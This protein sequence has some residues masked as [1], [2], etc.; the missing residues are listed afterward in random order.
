MS[1]MAAVVAGGGGGGGGLQPDEG[2]HLARR[3]RET[4][5]LRQAFSDD[6]EDDED[7]DDQ[8]D[9]QIFGQREGWEGSDALGGGEEEGGDESSEL[10]AIFR[11]LARDGEAVINGLVRNLRCTPAEA[12]ALT[13]GKGTMLYL[14]AEDTALEIRPTCIDQSDPR[15]V[16]AKH[17][18]TDAQRKLGATGQAP[19][20]AP[21]EQDEPPDDDIEESAGTRGKGKGRAATPPGRCEAARR[22]VEACAEHVKTVEREL[23]AEDRGRADGEKDLRVV[24]DVGG[25][26]LWK[27][28]NVSAHHLAAK[29]LAFYVKQKMIKRGEYRD[30]LRRQWDQP[31]AVVHVLGLCGAGVEWVRRQGDAWAKSF[32]RAMELLKAAGYT[33][34]QAI[35]MRGFAV[36]MIEV[37]GRGELSIPLVRPGNAVPSD[38]VRTLPFAPVDSVFDAARAAAEARAAAAAAAAANEAA[39]APPP[40][41]RAPT[42][43]AA[44]PEAPVPARPAPATDMTEVRVGSSV[45]GRTSRVVLAPVTERIEEQVRGN[46]AE[47]GGVLEVQ[48]EDGQ[49]VSTEEIERENRRVERLWDEWHDDDDEEDAREEEDLPPDHGGQGEK[50]DQGKLDDLEAFFG[51]LNNEYEQELAG[52][53]E[54][55]GVSKED[56]G[57]LQS[58]GI[59]YGKSA[60]ALLGPMGVSASDEEHEQ[61]K[62][63]PN[64]T[65]RRKDVVVVADFRRLCDGPRGGPS[66]TLLACKLLAAYVK[67]CV[68]QPGSES[69]GELQKE[70]RDRWDKGADLLH[71]FIL[72]AAASSKAGAV[73]ELRDAFDRRRRDSAWDFQRRRQMGELEGLGLSNG[74]AFCL[75]GRPWKLSR[76]PATFCLGAPGD[77]DQGP[78]PVPFAPLDDIIARSKQ[79][80]AAA[81]TPAPSSSSAPPPPPHAPPPPRAP[82]SGARPLSRDVTPILPGSSLLGKGTRGDIQPITRL[83]SERSTAATGPPRAEFFG[84]ARDAVT[85]NHHTALFFESLP[86]VFTSHMTRNPRAL[87]SGSGGERDLVGEAPPARR[88]SLPRAASRGRPINYVDL[89]DSDDEGDSGDGGRGQGSRP[90]T[91]APAWGGSTRRQPRTASGLATGAETPRLVVDRRPGRPQ[92]SSASSGVGGGGGGTMSSPGAGAHGCRRV[93]GSTASSENVAPASAPAPA[94]AASATATEVVDRMP[95]SPARASRRRSGG[96]D[97]GSPAHRDDGFFRGGGG[98]DTPTSASKRKKSRSEGLPERAS[99]S[100]TSAGRPHKRANSQHDEV[101][102]LSALDTA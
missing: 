102:L 39:A 22:A 101:D 5:A 20:E 45:R 64:E 62:G 1:T 89:I 51:D 81:A 44:A 77:D 58:A 73:Q 7:E 6:D 13:E 83:P 3:L 54:T 24:E 52:T 50:D 46:Q 36:Q 42:A 93:A 82:S 2:D 41:P 92:V 69:G 94:A 100:P 27:R 12:E 40:P 76:G 29:G 14:A 10:A 90:A 67:Q 95:L 37:D 8:L 16:R 9:D 60:E 11:E 80:D 56:A 70:V 35:C 23:E 30:R 43:A 96:G 31:C 34:G 79:A 85:S 33:N 26:R 71:V 49:W 18:L 86:A 32:A 74:V 47:L 57:V 75:R 98:G 99:A 84:L 91:T 78:L 87:E 55:L 17:A 25:L 97:P 53:M 59:L 4:D 15:L 61:L 66:G 88:S 38:D 65:R 28:T 63:D 21:P 48:G 72:S 19:E 68:L